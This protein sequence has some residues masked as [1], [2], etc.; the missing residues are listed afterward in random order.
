V[1]SD[2]EDENDD[3][4]EL[5]QARPSRGRATKRRI[6]SLDEDSEDYIQDDIVGQFESDDGTLLCNTSRSDT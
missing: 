6:V 3:S 2:D 5:I 4:F 1:V